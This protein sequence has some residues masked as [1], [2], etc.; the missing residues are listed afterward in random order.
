MSAP[1][2][3]PTPSQITMMGHNISARIVA[4]KAR[5]RRQVRVTVAAGAVA[6]GLGI[7]AAGIGVATAPPA[8]R[9]SMFSCYPADDLGSSPTGIDA[10]DGIVPESTERVA[11]ALAACDYVFGVNGV[12]TP[13][14]TA[15]ELPD[16]RLGVFPNVERVDDE[17]FCTSLGLGLPPVD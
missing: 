6:L 13:D 12:P 9:A 16:L 14:P 2:L 3:G 5:R 8:T 15:C 7:T 17:E 11:A 10:F 4:A 1:Q